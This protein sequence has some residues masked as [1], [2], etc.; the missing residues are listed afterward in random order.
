MVK[1]EIEVKYEGIPMQCRKKTCRYKWQYKGKSK[2][3]ACCPM[4]KTP[5]KLGGKNGKKQ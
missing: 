4:C 2:F 1:K 5:V 3:F